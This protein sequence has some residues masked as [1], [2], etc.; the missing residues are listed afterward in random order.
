MSRKNTQ[1][2]QRGGY[3]DDFRI[4]AVHLVTEEGYSV[5]A[6]AKAVGVSEPTLRA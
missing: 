6:A 2:R 5:A 1:N 3:A 4:G